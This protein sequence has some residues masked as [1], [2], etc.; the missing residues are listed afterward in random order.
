EA[1]E[2][3]A[4]ADVDHDVAVRDRRVVQHPIADGVEVMQLG[5]VPDLVPAVAA[6]E[7][8]RRPGIFEREGPMRGPRRGVAARRWSP[9][10]HRVLRSPGGFPEAIADV[11]GSITPPA[12]SGQPAPNESRLDGA[13]SVNSPR[14]PGRRSPAPTGEAHDRGSPP[15]TTDRRGNPRGGR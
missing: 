9:E 6:M 5:P 4:A 7:E 12:W 15:G 3:V 10:A 14:L 8:P 2:P 1:E 11:R 13:G